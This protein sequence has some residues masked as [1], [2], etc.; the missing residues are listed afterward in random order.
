MRYVKSR[1][2]C[3]ITSDVL[4]PCSAAAC[5]VAFAVSERQCKWCFA[6]NSR[7]C[8]MEEGALVLR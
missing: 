4:S 6:L 1:Y 3:T 2:E 5:C 7:A 8:N